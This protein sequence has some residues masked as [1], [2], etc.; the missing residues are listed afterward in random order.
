MFMN[1][2]DTQIYYIWKGKAIYVDSPYKDKYGQAFKTKLDK[3]YSV[4]TLSEAIYTKIAQD[5]ID[6]KIVNKVMVERLT[7]DK[8][9]KANFL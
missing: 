5:Y 4:F 7:S 2:E 9:I 1:L 8:V 3:D 6:L